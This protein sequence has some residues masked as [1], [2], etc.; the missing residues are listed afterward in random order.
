M[1]LR[2]VFQIMNTWD[3][4]FTGEILLFNDGAETIN[5]WDIAF[6]APWQ[7]RE[8]WNATTLSA[9]DNIDHFSNLDWNGTL[10]PGQSTSFGFNAVGTATPRCSLTK[11]PR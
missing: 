3:A 8:S 2:T 11:R 5:G 10:A 4:G 1:A 7:I 6:T 9:P